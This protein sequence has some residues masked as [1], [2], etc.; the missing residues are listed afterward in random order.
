MIIWILKPQLKCWRF[1]GNAQSRGTFL[2]ISIRWTIGKK[3]TREKCTNTY[4][5]NNISNSSWEVTI[6]NPWCQWSQ[7]HRSQTR[8][9]ICSLP[10]YR[11]QWGR[12]CLF[13]LK[14]CVPHIW[15][16]MEG[17]TWISWD[18]R[19]TQ[20][21]RTGRNDSYFCLFFC[22]NFLMYLISWFHEDECGILYHLNKCFI[23]DRRSYK[24]DCNKNTLVSEYG[25]KSERFTERVLEMVWEVWP[26]TWKKPKWP[27]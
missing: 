15:I 3:T 17:Q 18:F 6:T 20:W 23:N 1:T 2:T 8:I 24:L 4:C 26:I 10:K 22:S 25:A 19:W 12:W 13:R 5:N 7:I 27:D 21:A 11:A 14:W 9:L 16:P